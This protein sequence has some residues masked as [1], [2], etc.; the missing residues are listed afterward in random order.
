MFLIPSAVAEVPHEQR[1]LE[2]PPQPS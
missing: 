2:G 1:F